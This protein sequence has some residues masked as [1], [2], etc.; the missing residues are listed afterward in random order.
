MS[1][2]DKFTMKAKNARALLRAERDGILSTHSLDMP[3]YPFGSVTPYSLDRMGRPVILISDLAQHTKNIEDNPKVSLTITASTLSRD[4]QANARLTFLADTRKLEDEESDAKER[5]L[6]KFPHA[7]N[8]FSAHNFFFYVLELKRARYIEGFGKIWW[9]EPNEL[10]LESVFDYPSEAK[11][12]DH[13]NTDHKDALVKYCSEY[14]FTNDE[15]DYSMT[16]IDTEG[17]DIKVGS[18]SVRIPFDKP[19]EKASQ[20]REVLVAM[21][22][23]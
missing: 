12:L 10:E 21:T 19:L 20:A 13:M 6:R 17:I 11:V 1:E 9:V 3:G 15:E 16:G 22:K 7:K 2:Y 5:Y 4:V 18:E 23:K 8:Y 14:G